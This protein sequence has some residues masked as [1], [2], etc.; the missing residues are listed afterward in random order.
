[1]KLSLLIASLSAAM[2]LTG[3]VNVPVIS[4]PSKPISTLPNSANV[5]PNYPYSFPKLS[6]PSDQELLA[7]TSEEGASNLI[8]KVGTTFACA[9]SPSKFLDGHQSPQ[10]A[11]IITGFHS[12]NHLAGSCYEIMDIAIQKELKNSFYATYSFISPN[13]GE[14]AQRKVGLVKLNN[15]WYLKP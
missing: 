3:C 11:M 9:Q 12:R 5:L 15:T 7:L 13:S 8:K 1:M 4:Q 10:H 2:L 14:T 6:M